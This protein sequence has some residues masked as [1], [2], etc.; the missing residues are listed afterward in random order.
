MADGQTYR[1]LLHVGCDGLGRRA[2]GGGE[3]R[4]R[5]GQALQLGLDGHGLDAGRG[6]GQAGGGLAHA[7]GAAS[8]KRAAK[9]KYFLPVKKKKNI[10]DNNLSHYLGTL[11]SMR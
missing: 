11:P 8:W 10:H 5:G 2:G 1:Y 3:Q 9:K 7:A 4:G 6:G